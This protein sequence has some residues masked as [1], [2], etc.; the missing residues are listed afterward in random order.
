MRPV[1]IGNIL[2]DVD[3]S[4]LTMTVDAWC[5]TFYDNHQHTAWILVVHV[6]VD[7]QISSFDDKRLRSIDTDLSEVLCCFR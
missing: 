7:V 4:S 6:C 5:S 1:Y 3:I 2:I